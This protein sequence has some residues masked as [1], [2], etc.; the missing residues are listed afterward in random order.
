MAIVKP[1]YLFANWKMYLNFQESVKLAQAL[2]RAD[3]KLPRY[4]EQAIFPSAL[5]LSAVKTA[6]KNTR[7]AVGAQNFYWVDKGGYTGEVSAPMYKRAGCKYAL[8]G[9]S[10]RRHVFNETNQDTRRKLEAA[11]AENLTPILCVGETQK[12]RMAGKSVEVLE[13]QIRGALQDLKTNGTKQLFIAYEPVWAIGTGHA[14]EPHHAEEMHEHIQKMAG[15]LLPKI[16]LVI[17]Y[18]GSVRPENVAEY[19]TQKNIH[20]V[21]VGHA[22]AGVGSWL[23]ILKKCYV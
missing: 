5:A 15:G 18:G 4:I 1:I 11:L 2:A 20:G 10:E 9:H 12:E 16:K 22:S 8:V 17:L 13:I 3:K 21:L 19:L 6:L 7:V 23:K 14:C